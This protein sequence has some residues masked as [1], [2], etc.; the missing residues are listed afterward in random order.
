M[1]LSLLGSFLR[2]VIY[3]KSSLRHVRK[4]QNDEFSLWF[5]LGSLFLFSINSLVDSIHSKYFENSDK[6]WDSKFKYQ[7]THDSVPYGIYE[8]NFGVI[9]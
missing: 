7:S 8:N 6:N 9:D 2:I 1:G 5:S 4:L 3:L